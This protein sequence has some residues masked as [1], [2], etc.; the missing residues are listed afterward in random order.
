M[1]TGFLIFSCLVL[2]YAVGMFHSNLKHDRQL[3]EL[4]KTAQF[5][6]DI[7]D[8]QKK[9]IEAMSKPKG[10]PIPLPTGASWNEPR[11]S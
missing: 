7:A 4:Q 9:Q 3:A 6:F 11:Y 2:G 1:I 8:R 5:W 10:P